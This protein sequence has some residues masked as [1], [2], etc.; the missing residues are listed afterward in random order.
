MNIDNTPSSD[1]TQLS[2]HQ[3]K[4]IDLVAKQEQTHNMAMITN[5][6]DSSNQ[7][8][9]FRQS[10]EGAVNEHQ[11]VV[12][13]LSGAGEKDNQE[14]TE[15]NHPEKDKYSTRHRHYL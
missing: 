11:Q 1:N 14:S 9:T 13:K 10:V 15:T 2:E 8:E 5:S 4:M 3:Q 6:E 12:E 7:S